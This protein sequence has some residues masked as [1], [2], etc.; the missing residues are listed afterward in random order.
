M[1]ANPIN[2]NVS[3]HDGNNFKGASSNQVKGNNN[4]CGI[5]IMAEDLMDVVMVVMVVMVVKDVLN[6][7]SIK[8][9][10]M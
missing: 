8:R 6:V 9:L 4:S 2:S 10:D 3:N 5:L 7:N 1:Q